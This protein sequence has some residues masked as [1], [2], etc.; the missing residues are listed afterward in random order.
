MQVLQFGWSQGE[1]ESV[2]FS[3]RGRCNQQWLPQISGIPR[4][5]ALVGN[6]ASLRDDVVTRSEDFRPGF[7]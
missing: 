4:K 5:P 2:F 1:R 7:G 3:E 6:T